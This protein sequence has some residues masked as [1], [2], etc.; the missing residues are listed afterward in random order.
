MGI[1]KDMALWK[2]EARAVPR[3]R[4]IYVFLRIWTVCE[5]KKREIILREDALE[6]VDDSDG[7]GGPVDVEVLVT[8]LE[9]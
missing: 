9:T 6:L 5:I 2:R 4:K 8:T 3:T 7:E 1:Q